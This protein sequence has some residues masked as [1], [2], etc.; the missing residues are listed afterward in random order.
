[1]K[2][3]DNCVDSDEC[4]RS[5]TNNC[6]LGASCTN[7]DG[8]YTCECNEGFR[9]DGFQVGYRLIAIA[10]SVLKRKPALKMVTVKKL[11][12]RRRMTLITSTHAF[13]KMVLSVMGT[14]V[15]I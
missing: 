11:A 6:A 1:M 7:T 12:I 3:V 2:G 8:S 9:G 4:E 13:V 5:W 10:L 14:A 15:K